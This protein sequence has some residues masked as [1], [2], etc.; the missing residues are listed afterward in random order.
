MY[1]IALTKDVKRRLKPALW[2]NAEKTIFSEIKRGI[3]QVF[4]TDNKNM[5]VVGRM[6]VREFVIIAIVGTDLKNNR[7]DLIN[8]AI[9]KGALTMRM[10]TKNPEYLLKGLKG[11]S[12]KLYKIIPRS[13]GKD[14]LIYKMSVA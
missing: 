9:A 1:E 3:S 4:L 7:R 11:L 6:E 2:G 14:E 8:Y 5:L 10:H 13:F 12:I